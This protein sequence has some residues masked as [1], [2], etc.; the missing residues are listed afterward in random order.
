[1][2]RVFLGRAA[3]SGYKEQTS[4]QPVGRK[5]EDITMRHVRMSNDDLNMVRQG[6]S[7]GVPSGREARPA[8]MPLL[9]LHMATRA[10]PN[11]CEA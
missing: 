6:P 2:T 9:A 5:T 3:K 4:K 7:D 10:K 8:C 11:A 1:M